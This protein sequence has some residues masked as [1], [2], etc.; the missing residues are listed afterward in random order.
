MEKKYR[1][2]KYE[3]GNTS[4]FQAEC[5]IIWPCWYTIRTATST[6]KEAVPIKFP[7]IAQAR[8]HIRILKEQDI[9]KKIRKTVVG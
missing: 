8:D 6:F 4:W 9:K 5:C 1:I 7:N 3:Q 2:V